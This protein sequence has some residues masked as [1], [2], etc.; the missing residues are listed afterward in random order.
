M[1][2]WLNIIKHLLPRARAWRITIEKTLKQFFEGLTGMPED[3]RVY[4]NEILLNLYPLTTE[5]FDLWFEQFNLIRSGN[6]AIDSQSLAAAWLLNEYQSPK[7][8]QDTLQT[9]GF[10]LYVHEWWE[11][12]VVGTPQ[13]RNP[14][15]YLATVEEKVSAQAGS[16]T[17]QAGEP[18]AQ[19]GYLDYFFIPVYITA[20]GEPAMLCGEPEALCGNL[21]TPTGYALVNKT[22]NEPPPQ[23]PFDDNY[24][25][26]FLYI[27]GENW[28]DHAEIPIGRKNEL[29]T[30]LLKICPTEQWIG[31]LVD[32]I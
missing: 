32:F 23:I 25:P 31:V 29:E 22:D 10:D 24:W 28:P 6:D 15:G 1:I 17:M 9:A 7:Q 14:F 3:I 16:P 27:G 8:I 4:F 26:Y 21:K 30:L 19:A 5:A 18:K 13:A 12:P 11:L 20:C 2:N